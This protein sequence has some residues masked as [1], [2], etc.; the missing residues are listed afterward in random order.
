MNPVQFKT[1]YVL[2]TSVVAGT[3]VMYNS[4]LFFAT[5]E[6][7]SSPED[8]TVWAEIGEISGVKESGFFD[9]LFGATPQP[10]TPE[11]GEQQ[12]KPAR[13]VSATQTLDFGSGQAGG[14][15]RR[16]TKKPRRK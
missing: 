1:D 4:H 6:T 9:G 11:E 15:R 8:E 2:G 12:N 14:R 10:K 5:K 13:N 16:T 3:I 7:I